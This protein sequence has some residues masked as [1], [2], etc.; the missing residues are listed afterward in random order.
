MGEQMLCVKAA[1]E[2]GLLQQLDD[3]AQ[4]EEEQLL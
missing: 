4:E 2:V 3:E 1:V